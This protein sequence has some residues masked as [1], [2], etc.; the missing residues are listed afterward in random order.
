MSI[1]FSRQCEYALQAVMYLALK[2]EGEWTS[3]KELTKKLNI[4]YHFL[5]KILQSLTYKG[6]L[7]SQKGPAG[8]FA[9]GMP[10]K[11][12]T[13]FHI[14]EAI[15]GVDFTNKCVLGFP[16][17]S[18]KNPCAVHDKWGILRE[19]IYAMLVSKNIAQMAKEMR[20]PEYRLFAD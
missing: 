6:L 16:E 9:L 5:A 8:G 20:K 7:K 3:I 2:A 11:E 15:D 1:F 12:I 17:C 4:P 13:L 14:V 18:G 19:Q 10:A